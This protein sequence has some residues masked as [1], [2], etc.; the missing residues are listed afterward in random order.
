VYIGARHSNDPTDL[1][2]LDIKKAWDDLRPT[3]AFYEGAGIQMWSTTEQAIREAGEPGLVQFLAEK[4][5][6]RSISL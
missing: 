3:V 2:F 1:Q 4:D 5:S 6:I